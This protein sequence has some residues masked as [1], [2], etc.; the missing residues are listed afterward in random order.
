MNELILYYDNYINPSR[1]HNLFEKQLK[2]CYLT[3]SSCQLLFCF[4]RFSYVNKLLN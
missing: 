2:H 1:I 4:T 3:Y